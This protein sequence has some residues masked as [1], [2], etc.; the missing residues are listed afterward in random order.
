VEIEDL[1]VAQSKSSKP[2]SRNVMA[3]ECDA[4]VV[5]L[6]LRMCMPAAICR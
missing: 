2:G 5:P 3:M 6:E 1:R 4:S